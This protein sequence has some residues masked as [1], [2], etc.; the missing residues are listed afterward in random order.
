MKRIYYEP[1]PPT[2]RAGIAGQFVAGKSKPVSDRV[3]ALL[4]ARPEFREAKAD[5]PGDD[6]V[7]IAALETAALEEDKADATE[8]RRKAAEEKAARKGEEA[9]KETGTGGTD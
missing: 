1:G 9:A 4:L 2:L 6:S 7:E 3:A 5:T 8:A